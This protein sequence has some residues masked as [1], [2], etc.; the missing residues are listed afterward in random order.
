[1]QGHGPFSKYCK[2]IFHQNPG[3][4]DSPFESLSTGLGAGVARSDVFGHLFDDGEQLLVL[5]LAGRVQGAILPDHWRQ[6]HGHGCG[7][8]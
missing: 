4:D 3:I 2:I 5:G 7:G 1:M 8:R 6:S